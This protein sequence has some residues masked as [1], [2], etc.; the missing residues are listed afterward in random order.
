MNFGVLETVKQNF[1]KR[2]AKVLTDELIREGLLN[3]ED[4]EKFG[5]GELIPILENRQKVHDEW[6]NCR[7][8]AKMDALEKDLQLIDRDLQVIVLGIIE[9]KFKGEIK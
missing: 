8:H 7:D 3:K 4:M 6:W 2:E 9:I 5:L 1:I